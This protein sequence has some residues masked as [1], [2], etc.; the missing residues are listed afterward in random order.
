MS[1][2]HHSEDRVPARE[3]GLITISIIGL[4]TATL[5]MGWCLF[6]HERPNM[7]RPIA[8]QDAGTPR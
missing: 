8:M 1:V 7:P 5:F 4:V 2:P 3:E 6:D